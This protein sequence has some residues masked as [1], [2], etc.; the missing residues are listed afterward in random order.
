[1]IKLRMIQA[2]IIGLSCSACG[3]TFQGS[4]STLPEDVTSI[5]IP[6]VGNQSPET[7]FT[8]LLTESLRDRFD[9]YGVVTVLES[10]AR[11]DS[12]L[13]ADIKQIERSTSTSTSSSDFALQNAITVTIAAQLKR[14]D[15][16]QVLWANPNMTITKVYGAAGNTVV[17]SSPTFSA[18][19]LNAQDLNALSDREIARGQ[20]REVFAQISDQVA[21]QVYEQAVMP[22]F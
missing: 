17:T 9:R 11:A 7:K 8:K 5:H 2:I 10:P 13:E 6:Q 19:S 21:L 12:L 14:R 16:G 22:E 18:G 4:G 20:E 1:M 3:Y 15:T